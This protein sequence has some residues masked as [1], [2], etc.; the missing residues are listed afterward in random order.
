MIKVAKDI[1]TKVAVTFKELTTID[2][3]Y[4]LIQVTN[5]EDEVVESITPTETSESIDRYNYFDITTALPAGEYHYVAYQSST[6]N[7]TVND[8]V[9]EPVE[10]GIFTVTTTEDIEDNIYS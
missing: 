8:I 5:F 7:P 1:S 9:G 3:V 2:S 6:L 10:Y 4:Y